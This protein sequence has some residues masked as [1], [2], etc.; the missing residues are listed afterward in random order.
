MHHSNHKTP[1]VPAT[2]AEPVLRYCAALIHNSLI[3]ECTRLKH[4]SGSQKVLRL[5]Y[6][7]KREIEENT[8]IFQHYHHLCQYQSYRDL[9]VFRCLK[10]ES[11]DSSFN[12][13]LVAYLSSLLV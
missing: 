5:T 13:S 8:I 11:R 10:T 6:L 2:V 1:Q 4:M 12:A 3:T 9:E 7:N